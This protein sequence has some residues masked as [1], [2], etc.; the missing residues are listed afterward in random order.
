QKPFLG[1]I[2]NREV[3]RKP[4]F[5]DSWQGFCWKAESVAEVLAERVGGSMALGLRNLSGEPTCQLTT[6][7]RRALHSLAQGRRY[8][9]R[10]EYQGL[11]EASGWVAVRRRNYRD[12]AVRKLGPTDGRWEVLEIPFE[13]AAEPAHDVA[14]GTTVNG[15][16]T[17]IFIRSVV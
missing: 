10:L 15:P 7:L 17:T 1:R 6:H 14:F 11:S 5:P 4:W 12:I 9:L 3:Y 8:V 2:E 16:E 13:L